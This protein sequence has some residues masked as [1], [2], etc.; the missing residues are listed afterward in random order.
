[1]TV[2]AG[3]VTTPAGLLK[4]L[5]VKNFQLGFRE[6]GLHALPLPDGGIMER[7][8]VCIGD[9]RMAEAAVV[10][11]IGGPPDEA[12]VSVSPC[13]CRFVALVAVAAAPGQVGVFVDQDGV[14]QIAFVILFRLN[15][16]RCTCSP[17]T[18]GN[19]GRLD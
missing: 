13:L 7:L 8:A 2:A 5:F 14:D 16:R 11:V 19:G 15:W 1:M 4:H 6:T 18:G 3:G 10:K 12:F 9:L 17:F